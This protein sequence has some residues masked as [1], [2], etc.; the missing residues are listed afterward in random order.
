VQAF[1]S[2]YPVFP[3]DVLRGIHAAVTREMPDGTPR[4]GWHPEHRIS[5][6]RALRHFTRDAAYAS[7][8]EGEKGTLTAGRLA[9]FVVLTDD[10]LA[11]PASRLLTARVAMTVVGGRIVSRAQL[12]N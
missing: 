8:D 2:D 7:F 10:I 1:G 12:I 6:E 11:P 3:M 5:V 4:G 9:D